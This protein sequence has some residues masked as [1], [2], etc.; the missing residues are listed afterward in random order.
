M[1]F[2]RGRKGLT[3]DEQCVG[4]LDADGDEHALLHNSKDITHFANKT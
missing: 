4:V 2:V 3:F 1:L